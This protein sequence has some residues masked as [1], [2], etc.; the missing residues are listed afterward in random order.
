[1]SDPLDDQQITVSGAALRA[2]RDEFQRFLMEY[3][4]GLAEVETKISILREEFQEMHAY[5]PIEHVSSRVKSPDS[6]VDKVRRKGS[7]PTSTP[8]ARRSPTSPG[9]AS[10]AASSTTPTVCPSC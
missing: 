9:S 4:F 6:L 7:R 5:N 2:L 3:R 8:S 1:M 10:R